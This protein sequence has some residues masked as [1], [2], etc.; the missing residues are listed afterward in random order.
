[1]EKF[2]YIPE[3]WYFGYE[4]F[5]QDRIIVD[6]VNKRRMQYNLNL[7]SYSST[8]HGVTSFFITSDLKF[9]RKVLNISPDYVRIDFEFW[10]KHIL[11]NDP[12]IDED[13]I[14]NDNK[15]LNFDIINK[16]LSMIP[17]LEKEDCN[18]IYKELVNNIN[19]L[20]NSKQVIEIEFIIPE[21][22]Y[23]EVTEDNLEILSAWRFKSAYPRFKLKLG[24][25]TGIV[26]DFPN[27]RSHTPITNTK[28][29]GTKITYEQFL[30]HIYKNE[31]ETY[32][33][34]TVKT[35]EDKSN[36]HSELPF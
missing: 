10:F 12:I 14:N 15:E 2:K 6:W 36:P 5:Q 1:M 35:T 30:K 20:L 18:D 22:W 33:E 16:G 21:A 4:T 13:V 32:K 17:W 26:E 19:S 24:E 28:N 3:K 7:I 29:F 11:N 23:V 9:I 25:I 27:S 31:Y 34:E 8:I